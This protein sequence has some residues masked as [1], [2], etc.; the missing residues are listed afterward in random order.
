MCQTRLA[1]DRPTTAGRS[2]SGLLGSSG[3]PDNPCTYGEGGHTQHSLTGKLRARR[4]R[5]ILAKQGFVRPLLSWPARERRRGDGVVRVVCAGR[6]GTPALLEIDFFNSKTCSLDGHVSL[7]SHLP[8]LPLHNPPVQHHESFRIAVTP[9]LGGSQNLTV[10]HKRRQANL[11]RI[12]SPSPGRQTTNP[13]SPTVRAR[14]VAEPPSSPSPKPSLPAREKP[15]PSPED[16]STRTCQKSRPPPSHFPGAASGR[17]IWA[18][19]LGIDW[20]QLTTRV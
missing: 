10:C 19:V 13:R 12:L 8:P 17:G 7:L 1:H 4:R 5:R 18:T 15:G 2:G 20:D 6:P 9:D 16:M 3:S 14:G 11:K